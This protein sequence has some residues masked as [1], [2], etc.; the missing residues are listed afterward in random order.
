M[1]LLTF[2]SKKGSSAVSLPFCWQQSLLFANLIHTNI[3]PCC[4]LFLDAIA[5][6]S[7]YLRQWV[8]QSLGQVG[9]SL[10]FAST[11]LASLFPNNATTLFIIPQPAKSN[12]FIKSCLHKSRTTIVDL[13]KKF[14]WNICQVGLCKK[15]HGSIFTRLTLPSW[16]DPTNP[17]IKRICL[18]HRINQFPRTRF[19]CGIF[20]TH[21][22]FTENL[23]PFSV[24]EY[25]KITVWGTMVRSEVCN[26]W[27]YC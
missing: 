19:R 8:S 11:E 22:S 25:L 2:W 16:E 6:P 12:Y 20:I 24:K 14:R 10:D 13:C 7:T 15:F 3:C 23:L 26:S 9:D 21:I 18:Q 1:D 27:C 17:K 4:L 5:S